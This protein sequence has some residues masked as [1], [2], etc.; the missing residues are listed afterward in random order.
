MGKRPVRPRNTFKAGRG[1]ERVRE[2]GNK[3]GG[4]SSPRPQR[5]SH[6]EE[7]QSTAG[8]GSSGVSPFERP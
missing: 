7:V 3:M 1:L 2:E 5:G 6:T 8:D 4:A